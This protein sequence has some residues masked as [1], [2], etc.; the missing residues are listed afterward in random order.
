MLIKCQAAQI[1]FNKD[2]QADISHLRLNEHHLRVLN[3]ICDFLRIPHQVQQILSST[4][5][6][7]APL[8][9]PTYERFLDLLK[10]ARNKYSKIAHAI[11]ASITILKSYMTYTWCTRVYA[12]AMGTY[13]PFVSTCNA[14]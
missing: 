1:F 12:L 9:I 3:D 2:E 6:P 11:L 5:T 13:S 8:V 10:L 14:D 4:N 7:T